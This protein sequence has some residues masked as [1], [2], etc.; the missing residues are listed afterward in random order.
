MA[1]RED[2]SDDEVRETVADY[3][4]MLGQELRGAPYSK[5][6]HRRELAARLDGRSNP[7][8]EFK[9]A[10]IS[11]ALAE[12]DLRYIEGYKPRQLPAHPRGRARSAIGRR[13]GSRTADDQSGRQA[14]RPAGTG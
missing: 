7:S 5:A 8:I 13:P 1:R 9:H 2:W 10:N 3:L 12:R 4:E 11:A 14:L 6:G